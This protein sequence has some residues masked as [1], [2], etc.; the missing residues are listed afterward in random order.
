MRAGSKDAN[1]ALVVKIRGT[2]Q[3]GSWA[4]AAKARSTVPGGS[5]S[6]DEPTSRKIGRRT[7]PDRRGG[8]STGAR[9]RVSSKASWT[10]EQ[11]VESG[12]M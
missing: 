5:E 9:T 6:R 8:S 4:Q 3:V 7:P 2:G 11:Q 12:G 1:A 10:V